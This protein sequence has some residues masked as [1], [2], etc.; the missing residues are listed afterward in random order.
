MG[1]ER[2]GAILGPSRSLN[3]P[4]FNFCGESTATRLSFRA[5]GADSITDTRKES[6][7]SFSF[8][9]VVS[10]LSVVNFLAPKH[11]LWRNRAEAAALHG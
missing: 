9:S 6:N 11:D 5:R 1:A 4:T 10:E 3:F 7:S 2:R 8:V